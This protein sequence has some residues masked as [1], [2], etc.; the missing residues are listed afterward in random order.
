MAWLGTGKRVLPRDVPLCKCTK[1]FLRPLG[2]GTRCMS[3]V[4]RPSASSPT[5]RLRDCDHHYRKAPGCP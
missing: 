5:A 3:T 1:P 4:N 2:V